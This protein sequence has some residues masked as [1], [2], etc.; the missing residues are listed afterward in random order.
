MLNWGWSPN[1]SVLPLVAGETVELFAADCATPKSQFALGETICAKTDGVD[2][3][4][5]GN[6]YMNWIDSSLNQTNGGT[7][8]QNPQFFLFVP[9]STGTWKATIGRVTPADSSIIGNPPLFTVTNSG[10]G[11]STFTPDCVTA[12]TSFVLGETVCATAA[13]TGGATARRR[14]IW[15]DPSGNARQVNDV[16]ADPESFSFSIPA[17]QTSVIGNDTVD[18]RGKWK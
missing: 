12:K 3:S 18:N 11:V 13:G 14:V 4:V 6:Y 9:P 16:T 8:T 7:I 10:P 2:L 5:A 17:T 15:I 1:M